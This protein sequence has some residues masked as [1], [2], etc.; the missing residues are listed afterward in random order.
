MESDICHQINNPQNVAYLTPQ[1]FRAKVESLSLEKPRCP[2]CDKELYLSWDGKQAS[3]RCRDCRKLHHG[4]RRLGVVSLLTFGKCKCGEGLSVLIL[5][6]NQ[7]IGCSA[8]VYNQ[9]HHSR[10][11]TIEEAKQVLN[12]ED[13]WTANES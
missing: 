3:W 9:C 13:R 11:L 7:F 4:S 12:L 8:Y 5:S 10:E 1:E 2:R 6:K